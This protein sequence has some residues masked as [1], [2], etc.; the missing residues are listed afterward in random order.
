[1]QVTRTKAR[2]WS[3]RPKPDFFEAN[4]VVPL[5]RSHDLFILELPSM[6]STVFEDP[7][8]VMMIRSYGIWTIM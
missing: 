5:P 6:L 3:S 1:M 2:Q 8:L 7:I 4:A